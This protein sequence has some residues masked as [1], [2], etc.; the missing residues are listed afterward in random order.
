MPR[1]VAAAA[2]VAALAAVTACGPVHSGA[3]AT[4]GHTRISV[5]QVQAATKASLAASGANGGPTADSPDAERTALTTLIRTD[6]LNAA[7]VV[8]KVTVSEGDV[9]DFLAKLRG[10][11]GTDEDTAK[12]NNIPFASLHQL[13]Y[14]GLLVQKLEQSVAP[15]QTDATAMQTA[16]SNYLIA[17][18]KQ[19][20][21]T[22]SPR[23]GTW[24]PAQFGVV[25]ADGFSTAVKSPIAVP[26]S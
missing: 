21:V 8:K 18:A 6:V 13:A 19:R 2:A 7:A 26:S 16:L 22:I 1:S 5:A 9:Q 25:A 12:N 24:D 3:A 15:G 4:V 17:L 10:T 20:G 23:Y 14:Q 11:N